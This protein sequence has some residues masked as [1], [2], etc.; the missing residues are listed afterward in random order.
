M[1]L[2]VLV[3][4][5]HPDDAELSCSGTI[6][7]LVTQGKKVGIVDFTRG[8]LGT[9][10]TPELREE[11]AKLAA[12]ILGITIRE[13]LGFDD[14]FFIIDRTHQLVLIQTIRKYCPEI[15]LANAIRDRHTDHGRAAELAREACFLSGLKKINTFSEQGKK[16]EAW[17]PRVL[18][19]YIQDYHLKPSFVVDITPYWKTKMESVQAFKSQ[20]FDPE[21]DEPT[22]PISTPEFVN[23]LEGRAR[24]MGRMIGVE[25]GEGF[26]KATPPGIRNLFDLL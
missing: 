22:T 14:G 26:I 17:R 8:E 12:Q 7:S 15:V 19:H 23:F 16:Q 21:S 10:G 20:F 24:E 1:K 18:Y 9:R 2:D 5:A 4:A 3:F 11:E 13:N 6:A 25:F